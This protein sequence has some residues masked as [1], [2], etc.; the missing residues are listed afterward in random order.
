MYNILVELGVPMKLVRL[1]KMCLNK[2]YSKVHVRKHLCD[3]FPI[4]NSAK[5][6]HAYSPLVFN[7]DLEYAIRNVLENQVG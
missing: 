7:F 2:T 3:S 1:N 4:Q 6:G 5:Q